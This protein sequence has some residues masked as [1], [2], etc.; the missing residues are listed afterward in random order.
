MWQIIMRNWD[1]ENFVC[2]SIYHPEYGRNN[3]DKNPR[4]RQRLNG[5]PDGSDC[6]D[7]ASYHLT[8]NSTLPITQEMGRVG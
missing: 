7:G 5:V 4:V 2:E 6:T 8:K 3:I 1:L